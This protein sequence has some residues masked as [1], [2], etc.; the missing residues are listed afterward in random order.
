MSDDFEHAPVLRQG[1]ASNVPELNLIRVFVTTGDVPDRLVLQATAE[2]LLPPAI[3][4]LRD[5]DSEQPVA[6]LWACLNKE[7]KAIRPVQLQGFLLR[8]KGFAIGDRRFLGRF[9]GRRGHGVL[10]T[11]YTGEVYVLD[12]SIMP[13]A[14]R[15]NL[16]ESPS[17]ERLF[18]VLR[19][20][21]ED[22]DRTADKR[23]DVLVE[24]ERIGKGSKPASD[25]PR[26]LDKLADVGRE[27]GTSAT[28]AAEQLI[29]KKNQ[30]VVGV[31][32]QSPVRPTMPS[33]PRPVTGK[34]DTKP[35]NAQIVDTQ[36]EDTI[37]QTLLALPILWPTD[38]QEVIGIVDETL[39]EDLEPTKYR[40]CARDIRKRLDAW[41]QEDEDE[42]VLPR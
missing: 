3:R 32:D 9:W 20:A 35:S 28:L 30:Q 36:D 19:Q 10:Y 5:P 39:Q 21:F 7:R 16:E 6:F 11:W 12:P 2:G 37:A 18:H 23:R 38:A 34:L 25:L 8:L 15:N 33:P 41:E 29:D 13:T 22:L 42:D 1:I 27:L 24:I 31:R 14:D 40:Q 4:L 26:L 17:R